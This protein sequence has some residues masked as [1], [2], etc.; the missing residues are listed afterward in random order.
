M[1]RDDLLAL[2]GS[3][4]RRLARWGAS[5]GPEWFVRFS[6]PAIG[7]FACALA[8]GRRRVVLDNLRRVRGERGPLRDA[9][10]VGRTF[11]TYASCLA[12]I[13]GASAARTRA[14]DALVWGESHMADALAEGRGVVMVTAHTA[15]WEMVGPLMARDYALR[16]MIGVEPEADGGARAIQDD[17]RR[18]H[19]M[20]VAHV[21]GDPLSALSLARHLREGGA[22][23]LQMDR[24]PRGMR[25]RS[26]TMFG[27]PA[28]VPE[29]PLRLAMVTGAPLV[30]VFAARTGHRAYEVL[31][32]PAVRL[33][34][35]AGDAELDAAAQTL[36]DAMGSFVAAHPTNWFHF[37]DE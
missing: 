22:V 26:V 9:V 11:A 18:A 33:S 3:F 28:R 19:G 5:R 34:R 8:P 7:V 14:T 29:G 20:V 17:A 21:G 13:L 35:R 1:G 15:G 37:R 12:E 6:P 27:A 23:A 31:V 2:D 32:H 36:A 4:W 24:V 10:D 30:A 25:T 16:V